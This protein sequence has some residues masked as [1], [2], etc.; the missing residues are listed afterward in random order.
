MQLFFEIIKQCVKR[1]QIK[2]SCKMD[3]WEMNLDKYDFG[4]FKN[5]TL[6]K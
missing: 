6:R 5:I 3:I 2:Y 4:I 1:V